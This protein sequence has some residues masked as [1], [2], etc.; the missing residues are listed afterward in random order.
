MMNNTTTSSSTAG[1]SPHPSRLST[2]KTPL[3]ATWR[4][5]SGSPTVDGMMRASGQWSSL[6]P[7]RSIQESEGPPGVLPPGA[8][9]SPAA[10]RGKNL[11]PAA[12]RGRNLLTAAPRGRNMSPAASRG[13]NLTQ[14]AAGLYGFNSGPIG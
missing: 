9:Y 13:R 6:P 14:S 5:A 1:H 3:S 10:S 4:P 8:F 11:S 2:R 12:P 7:P